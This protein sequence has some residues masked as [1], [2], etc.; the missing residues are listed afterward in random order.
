MRHTR[1]PQLA[2]GRGRRGTPAW[3][4]IDHGAIMTTLTGRR[5]DATTC[6]F[7]NTLIAVEMTR[8]VARAGLYLPLRCSSRRSTATACDAANEL[9]EPICTLGAR[10][11]SG[12]RVMRFSWRR[13]RW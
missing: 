10:P 5:C 3:A 9:L 1:D 4:E 8:H 7:G 13:V 6:V 2:A 11:R 12:R